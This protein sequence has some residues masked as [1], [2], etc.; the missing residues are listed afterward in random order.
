MTYKQ[1][2]GGPT[3]DMIYDFSVTWISPEPISTLN[4]VAASDVK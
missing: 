3:M 1:R 4:I 2:C